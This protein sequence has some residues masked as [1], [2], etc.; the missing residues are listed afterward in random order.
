M[1]PFL[2]NL[3]VLHLQ[4]NSLRHIPALPTSIKYYN[5][6]KNQL[7]ALTVESMRNLVSLTATRKWEM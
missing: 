5:V 7:E 2:Q 3:E 6:S 1:N 4:A